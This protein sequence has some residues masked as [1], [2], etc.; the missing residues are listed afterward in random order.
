MSAAS[1]GESTTNAQMKQLTNFGLLVR[2]LP[3]NPD[4]DCLIGSG[5]ARKPTNNG[6]LFVAA[7][8]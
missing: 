4:I 8:G 5:V 3:A 7:S 1:T 2:Q 6:Q